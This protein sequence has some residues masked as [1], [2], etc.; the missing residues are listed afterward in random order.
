MPYGKEKIDRYKLYRYRFRHPYRWHNN[1]EHSIHHKH[2]EEFKKYHKYFKFLRPVIL[3]TNLF[4]W[5]L[6]FRYVGIKTI[7]VFIGIFIVTKG[8]IEFFFLWR[9]EKRIFRPILKLKSGFDEIAKGNYNVKIETDQKN[10]ISLLT[11]SFNDMALK[12]QES[13]KVKSEYEENRK[14]LIANISHD[15][16]TPITSIQGYIE[17]ILNEKSVSEEKKEIY[18]KTIFNNSIYINKLIDDLFLFS[19]LDMEKLNFNFEVINFNAFMNDLMEEFR[20][21]F[22][23]KK[24]VFNYTSRIVNDVSVNIDRK[25]IC[26]VFRNVIGN[27]IRY[28]PE[29]D[30]KVNIEIYCS[31]MS[32]FTI[33]SDN[34]P[35]IPAE[36][37]P[38]VFERFYRID[39]ERSKDFVSTG[40]GLAIAREL[41]EAH[42]GSIRVENTADKGACFTIILPVASISNINEGGDNNEKHIDN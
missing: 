3:L 38:Y 1:A 12:L 14:T 25:R 36:K 42:K 15:L 16:K 5:Y 23:E 6:L 13:E 21:E 24:F 10:A 37:L 28:G 2:F 40:L 4:I 7:S 9:L 30:L 35:G 8:T 41:V 39:T 33:I 34:G 22:E 32:V 18:L 17:L 27:A 31:D 20:F 11:S 26:Q 19:K 29:Q